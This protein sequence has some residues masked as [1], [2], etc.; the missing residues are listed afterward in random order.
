MTNMFQALLWA[1]GISSERNSST[2]SPFHGANVPVWWNITY[3]YAHDMDASWWAQ[4]E[5]WDQ[6]GRK[7][8]GSEECIC[9]QGKLYQKDGVWAKTWQSKEWVQR[10]LQGISQVKEKTQVTRKKTTQSLWRAAGLWL[11]KNRVDGEKQKVW[12]K[13][14]EDWQG[15]GGVFRERLPY[16]P[17]GSYL[18]AWD[19]VEE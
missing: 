5:K 1:L 8:K 7:R 11:A 2:N 17:N 4:Q 16:T 9:N 14:Q 13:T 10:I 12:G 6:E 19:S 18:L 3:Q 15:Q